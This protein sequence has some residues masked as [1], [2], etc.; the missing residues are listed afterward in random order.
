MKIIVS[1]IAVVLSFHGMSCD[2]CG[3]SSGM[4]AQGLLPGNQFH[5]FSLQT[6]YRQTRS[7]QDVLFSDEDRI[8][9]EH[10]VRTNISGRWQISERW[11]FLGV[12]SYNYNWQQHVD[13]TR[14]M[15]GI[16]DINLHA[17]YLL[18]NR[19]DSTSSHQFRVDG[20]VKLPTG[21]YS[22]VALETSNLFP[23]SGS[24]DGI[25]RVNYQFKRQKWGMIGEGAFGLQGVNSAGYR[26]GNS[27]LS[28]GSIFGIKKIRKSGQLMPFLGISYQWVGTD[29]INDIPVSPKFNSGHL[30]SGEAGVQ[31]IQS[32]WMFHLR[33]SQPVYQHLSN[34]NV[35]TVI[36]NA[37]IGIRYLIQKK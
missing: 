36:G 2:V 27:V 11:A 25:F 9:R 26:F 4:G 24:I 7:F 15:H 28:S 14:T 6:T 8:S 23:G 34:G 1:F 17:S 30:V 19:S 5:F 29:E 12:V 31:F 33:F 13:S 37:E 22:R 35:K 3:A 32:N 16:G 10:F 20:G 18:I 21:A